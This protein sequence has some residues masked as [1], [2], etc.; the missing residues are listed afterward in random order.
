MYEVKVPVKNGYECRHSIVQTEGYWKVV[1]LD[2][3]ARPESESKIFKSHIK[4]IEHHFALRLAD[5][6][7]MYIQGYAPSFYEKID[8]LV[9]YAFTE[10]DEF[11]R[12]N[13]IEKNI[14][15]Q[16]LQWSLINSYCR[17]MSVDTLKLS[18]QAHKQRQMLVDAMNSAANNAATLSHLRMQQIFFLHLRKRLSVI[19]SQITFDG[20]AFELAYPKPSKNPSGPL[21]EAALSAGLQPQSAADIYNMAYRM[22]ELENIREESATTA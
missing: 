18:L 4:V 2:Y 22:L 5:A 1:T 7:E 6:E 15:N 20:K 17:L 21:Y 16:E 14:Q 12:I 10:L 9:D 3:M 13:I 8:D 19:D 11:E